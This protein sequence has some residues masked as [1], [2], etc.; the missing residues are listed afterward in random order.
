MQRLPI[1]S[2]PVNFT[3][4][5]KS[6]KVKPRS[7]DYNILY[8]DL[9]SKCRKKKFY[10]EILFDDKIEK[11]EEYGKYKKDPTNRLLISYEDALRWNNTTSQVNEYLLTACRY[12]NLYT[13]KK[14]INRNALETNE[15]KCKKVVMNELLSILPYFEEISNEKFTLRLWEDLKTIISRYVLIFPWALLL[16]VYKLKNEIIIKCYSNCKNS[17]QDKKVEYHFN[18]HP[19]YVTTLSKN[20]IL[21]LQSNFNFKTNI[22]DELDEYLIDRIE[23]LHKIYNRLHNLDLKNISSDLFF[24]D[25]TSYTNVTKTNTGIANNNVANIRFVNEYQFDNKTNKKDC[26]YDVDI[27]CFDP[28]KENGE[29][30]ENYQMYLYKSLLNHKDLYWDVTNDNCCSW[31]RKLQIIEDKIIKNNAHLTHGFHR[32]HDF[33][34]YSGISQ[35]LH[36]KQVYNLRGIYNELRINTGYS[37]R[38]CDYMKLDRIG[39]MN[40]FYDLIPCFFQKQSDS[41]LLQCWKLLLNVIHTYGVE[42]PWALFFSLLELR[43]KLSHINPN[44]YHNNK[45]KTTIIKSLHTFTGLFRKC[46]PN[47]HIIIQMTDTLKLSFFVIWT[48]T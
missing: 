44:F 43:S 42:F 12:S 39:L 20:E 18:Q 6:M 32:N 45:K 2:D 38:D 34:Q 48:I 28:T 47:I 35:Q 46:R 1:Q 33:F 15:E 24:F 21:H 9:K 41:N 36:E 40:I 37:Y 4:F 27:K 31:N 19:I 14:N 16:T 30:K 29:T 13:K 11:W 22:V 3:D 5:H 7:V 10:G 17:P 26:T 8:F 23:Y 25:T